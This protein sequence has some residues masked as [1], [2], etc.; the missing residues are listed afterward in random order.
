M[1]CFPHG[2]ANVKALSIAGKVS[3]LS[4]EKGEHL[5]L[6]ASFSD[7]IAKTLL[8]NYFKSHISSKH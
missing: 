3:F 4:Q 2:H 5:Y 1:E 8:I 6:V 7:V